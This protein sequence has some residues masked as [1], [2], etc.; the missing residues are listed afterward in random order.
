MTTSPLWR[1]LKSRGRRIFQTP[2]TSGDITGPTGQ[3]TPLDWTQSEGRTEGEAAPGIQDYTAPLGEENANPDKRTIHAAPNRSA[4]RRLIRRM[5]AAWQD[6]RAITARL[7]ERPV[8]LALIAWHK[9]PWRTMNEE[10]K[11]QAAEM[12]RRKQ[13]A[14]MLMTEANLYW[15]RIQNALDR[16]GY[17]HRPTTQDGGFRVTRHVEFDLVKLSPDTIYM[18]INTASLPFGVRLTQLVADRDLLSDLSISCGRRIRSYYTEQQ[19]AWFLIER[20]VGVGGIPMHVQFEELLLA[21]PASADHLTIP[22]GITT[23]TK[24]IYRSL[25]KMYSMLVAGSIGEGKSNFLNVILCALIRR[26]RPEDLRLILIDLKG[27]LEFQYYETIPHLIEIG[28]RKITDNNEQVPEVLHWLHDEGERR[29]K[30]LREAGHK[31]IGHFNAHRKKGRLPHI[32]LVIDEWADIMYDPKIK[33]ECMELLANIAQR[34]RAE[35]VHIIVCT[36]IPKVEVVPA[37]IKGVLPCKIAFSVPTN[38]A[39]MVIL[40]ND[41]AKALPVKGRC[42]LQWDGEIEVQTPFINSAIVDA[43]VSQAISGLVDT[44]KPGHDV[45]LLEVLEY[46]LESENGYL[47]RDRLHAVFGKRGLTVEE[48]TRWLSD[49]ENQTVVVS[50]SAYEIQPASGS[51]SRRLIAKNSK[52]VED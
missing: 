52:D 8:N 10:E 28:G 27:G 40:D 17:A 23:N 12:A 11:H 4:I 48:L 39:S 50:A 25:S 30:V 51:R 13:Q 46:A 43:S 31:D 18:R 41:N 42:I 47:S 15:D 7:V 16:Y 19:G 29:M 21:M 37:R 49:L 6:R 20:A 14:N 1:L 32:L 33:N 22:I 45:T 35:G 2:V 9:R 24:L 5:A 38:A 26:N 36:Q 3:R 34:L 44:P